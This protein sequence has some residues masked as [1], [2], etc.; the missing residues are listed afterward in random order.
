MDHFITTLWLTGFIVLAVGGLRLALR[1]ALIAFALVREM[2]VEAAGRTP[3]ATEDIEPAAI[4]ASIPD[5][6]PGRRATLVRQ[7][8]GRAA[9]SLRLAI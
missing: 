4:V 3:P 2:R 9:A 1:A 5:R 8:G 6:R 7:T